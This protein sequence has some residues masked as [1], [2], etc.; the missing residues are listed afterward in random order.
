MPAVLEAHGKAPP[1]MRF[2]EW[3][4]PRRK[5]HDCE[6]DAACLRARAVP[7]ERYSP[8]AAIHAIKALAVPMVDTGCCQM[9]DPP[10][11]QK[12]GQQHA[13]LACARSIIQLAS[14]LKPRILLS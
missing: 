1:H 8:V 14:I 7:A 5:K 2:L 11:G 9:R 4:A 10:H 6:P 12:E 13:S 3:Q